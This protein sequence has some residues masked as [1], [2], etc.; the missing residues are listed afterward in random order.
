MRPFTSTISL[1]EAHKRL[2]AAVRPLVRN[3][4]VPLTA[5]AGRVAAWDVTSPI[6]VPRVRFRTWNFKFPVIARKGI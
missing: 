1:E 4:R 2:E 3:E 6:D 5:A